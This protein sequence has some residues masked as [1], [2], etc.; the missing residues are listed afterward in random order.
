[1]K[2]ILNLFLLSLVAFAFASC[3][4]D[5][6]DAPE[7]AVEGQVY[8]HNGNPLQT[9]QGQGN[10]K[11]RIKEISYANGDPNHVRRRERVERIKELLDANNI[12]SNINEI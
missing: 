3:E 5:N 9:A 11:I 1:M 10:M 12:V 6:Y 2:K 4:M 8:D 7:A